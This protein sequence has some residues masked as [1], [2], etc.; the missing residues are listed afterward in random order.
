[1]LYKENTLTC[2]SSVIRTEFICDPFANIGGLSFWSCTLIVKVA[3]IFLTLL[4]CDTRH[5]ILN[6]VTFLG[7]ASNG[8]NNAIDEV[9]GLILK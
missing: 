5:V 4:S 6:V 2:F 8:N 3:D 7:S 9:V 1:M